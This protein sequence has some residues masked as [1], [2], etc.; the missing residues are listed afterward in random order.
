MSENKRSIKQP[1]GHEIRRAARDALAHYPVGEA[2]MV[3]MSSMIDGT[4]HKKYRVEPQDKREKFILSIYYPISSMPNRNQIESTLLWLLALSGD[5]SLVVQEPVLDRVGNLV[6]EFS[7]EDTTYASTLLRWIE[8]DPLWI[9]GQFIKRS[10]ADVS[11]M[12]AV[13]AQLHQHSSQWALPSGFVRPECRSEDSDPH[14]IR[15]SLVSLREADKDGETVAADFAVLSETAERIDPLFMRL[16]KTEQT[17][18]LIHDALHAANFVICGEQL[19][20][21]DFDGCCFG[22]YIDD[23]AFAFMYMDPQLR[24]AFLSGYERIRKLSDDH[25]RIIEASLIKLRITDWPRWCGW[26]GS[27]N[28]PFYG[29][30]REGMAFVAKQCRSYLKGEPFLCKRTGVEWFNDRLTI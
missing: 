22:Y 21:I 19:C 12:G 1:S 2:E 7:V 3:E 5:T 4:G 20:P 11:R 27:R 24:S 30:L 8:G 10:Q 28:K 29:Q 14:A 26:E 17:W 16:G 6:T 9:P 23:I 15:N 18:G 25:Q 13:A